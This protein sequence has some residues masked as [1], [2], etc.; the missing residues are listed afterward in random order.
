M[1]ITVLTKPTLRAV[2]ERMEEENTA[3][4]RVH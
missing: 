3:P 2:E 1:S 4:T